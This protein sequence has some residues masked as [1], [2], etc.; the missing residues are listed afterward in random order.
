VEN[1]FFF[2]FLNE[3]I[4]LMLTHRIT[5][6]ISCKYSDDHLVFVKMCSILKLLY[7]QHFSLNEYQ[8]CIIFIHYF[9]YTILL[10]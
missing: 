4:N 3:Q 9:S 10:F 8:N 7:K 2:F 6:F 5:V 1:R